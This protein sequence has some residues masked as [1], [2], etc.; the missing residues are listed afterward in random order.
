MWKTLKYQ[1]RIENL[2]Y[3]R[4]EFG[5]VLAREVCSFKA[6]RSPEVKGGGVKPWKIVAIPTAIT[7]A[8]ASI[9]MF[10]VWKKRHSPAAGNVPE[11]KVTM[12]D[13]AVVRMEFPA[14]FDDL[15]D[16]EGKSVWMKN[17]YT[18]PYFSYAGG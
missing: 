15:K 9:Y 13:V 10:S 14:H 2:S 8:I 12:D 1:L 11:Q 3:S 18:I 6:G 4:F 7:L 5:T 17:G 16:L